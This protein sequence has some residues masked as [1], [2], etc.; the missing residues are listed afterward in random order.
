[1]HKLIKQ[2]LQVLIGRYVDVQLDLLKI[3]VASQYVKTVDRIRKIIFI[4][5][6]RMFVIVL[7]GG[8]LILLP[9]ALCMFMPW[10][11]QTR[12]IVAVCFAGAY[13]IFPLIVLRITLS[14]RLWMKLTRADE[15]VRKIT[16][17]R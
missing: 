3:E 17:R 12:A 10:T 11:E 7:L 15:V 4:L 14:E 5:A 13:I 6:I 1:M 8:G 9:I 2:L 16:K